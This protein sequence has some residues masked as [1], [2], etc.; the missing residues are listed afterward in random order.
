M[1]VGFI[2]CNNFFSTFVLTLALLGMIVLL[3]T[4]QPYKKQKYTKVDITAIAIM[5][6]AVN[7]S[8]ELRGKDIH[9]LSSNIDKLY[10]INEKSTLLK[11]T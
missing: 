8:W 1:H 9:S 11:I 5:C 7:S 10:L 3:A 4:M 2:V 6:L